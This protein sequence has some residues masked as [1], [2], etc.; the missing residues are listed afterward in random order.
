[1][2]CKK[3]A[4]KLRKLCN[5]NVLFAQTESSIFTVYN[6]GPFVASSL[7]FLCHPPLLLIS[8]FTSTRLTMSSF[9]PSVFAL[10]PLCVICH[11]ESTLTNKKE[12]T[13][14]ITGENWKNSS[15]DSVRECH[16][17]YCCDVLL[18]NVIND[19]DWL[20]DTWIQQPGD[21]MTIFVWSLL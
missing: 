20:F 21:K 5:N 19:F 6:E 17:A 13:E 2:C 12:L 7:S 8:M 3:G 4:R 1:M 10:F 9:F 11:S 18:D 14:E 15:K 16:K